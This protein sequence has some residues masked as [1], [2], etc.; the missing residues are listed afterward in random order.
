VVAGGDVALT[1]QQ[2]SGGQINIGDNATISFGPGATPRARSQVTEGGLTRERSLDKE[3]RP[4]PLMTASLRRTA[5][6]MP[7]TVRLWN[8]GDWPALQCVY[9]AKADDEHGLVAWWMTQPVDF[10]PGEQ[11]DVQ[12]GAPHG[13]EQASFESASNRHWWPPELGNLLPGQLVHSEAFIR[14]FGTV[15]WTMNGEWLSRAFIGLQPPPDELFRPSDALANEVL[16]CREALLWRCAHG[17]VHRLLPH[18][19]HRADEFDP[20]QSSRKSI[21][22]YV[23]SGHRGLARPPQSTEP[24]PGPEFLRIE[25]IWDGHLDWDSTAGSVDPAT[26]SVAQLVKAWS[27]E[28]TQMGPLWKSMPEVMPFFVMDHLPSCRLAI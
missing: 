16:A 28:C 17:H 25:T 15:P 19:F 21:R 5:G 2:V 1:H 7:V 24:I 22:W 11:R 12:L 3:N 9:I 20:Q 18:I 13:I 26:L 14:A 23:E 10:A 6:G 4:E 8:L 27:W